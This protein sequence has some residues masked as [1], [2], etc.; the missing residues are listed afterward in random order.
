MQ[1]RT[2][3]ELLVTN[4]DGVLV[5]ALQ[6]GRARTLEPVSAGTK[7]L[8]EVEPRVHGVTHLISDFNKISI[9]SWLKLEL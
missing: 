3:P 9:F 2:H 5:V 8:R 1:F 7:R 4:F 6:T